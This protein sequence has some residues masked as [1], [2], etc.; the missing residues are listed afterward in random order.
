MVCIARTA[1]I[2]RFTPA[3]A[4]VV[5]SRKHSL[6][7]SGA[8]H[9]SWYP[10]RE[11]WEG[12]DVSGNPGKDGRYASRAYSDSYLNDNW[13]LVRYNSSPESPMTMSCL[14][15]SATRISRTYPPA[16]VMASAAAS[17]Q[18]EELVPITS[19]TRYTL[20]TTSHRSWWT[21]PQWSR[22]GPDAAA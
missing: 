20:M 4:A 1:P 18:E 21:S 15:T 17:S 3:D 2:S 13:I 6:S 11:Q 9:T 22:S 19:I 7:I 10:V 8:P 14:V 12:P 5:A 16:V